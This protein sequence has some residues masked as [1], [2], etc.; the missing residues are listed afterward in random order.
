[1]RKGIGLFFITIGLTLIGIGA[2]NSFEI[3]TQEL[4]IDGSKSYYDGLYLAAGDT[5][6]VDSIDL[7][8]LNVTINNTN[9]LFTYNGDYYENEESGFYIIFNNNELV[10]YKDNEIIRTLTKEK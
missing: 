1:M 6:V 7:D 5:V 3:L 10:L 8:N 9:Y 2:Y 4:I